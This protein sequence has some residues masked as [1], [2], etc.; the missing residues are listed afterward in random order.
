MALVNCRECGHE[1]S[2]SAAACVK[3]GAPVVAE[4]TSH[5]KPVDAVKLFIY[6]LALLIFSVCIIG[7]PNKEG[8]AAG[9]AAMLILYVYF[10]PSLV[11]NS[12]SKNRVSVFILNLF[13]GW[14]LLGWIVALAIAVR[15][16]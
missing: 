5:Q 13:L 9:T 4:T 12:Q 3:C 15:K 14:T 1:I 8:F 11:V 10:A 6:G 2:T 7:S 16:D